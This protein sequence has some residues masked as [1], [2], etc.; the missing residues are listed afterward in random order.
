MRKE[1]RLENGRFSGII[2][3][4]YLNEVGSSFLAA[5]II[6]LLRCLEGKKLF[7]DTKVAL[8]DG[9]LHTSLSCPLNFILVNANITNHQLCPTR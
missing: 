9:V 6:L 3:L 5:D 2:C 1:T 4:L 7:G 8:Q